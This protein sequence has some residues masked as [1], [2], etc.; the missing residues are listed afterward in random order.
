MYHS[1][2]LS[3]VDILCQHNKSISYFSRCLIT[4]F[5]IYLFQLDH[6]S[7]GPGDPLA[8][9]SQVI[10]ESTLPPGTVAAWQQEA[11]LVWD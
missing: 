1:R 10:G 9:A 5:F 3:N 2:L 7:G 8:A 4:F 11:E 6:L